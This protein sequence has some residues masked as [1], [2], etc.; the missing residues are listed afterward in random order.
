MI[1]DR[2]KVKKQ[3]EVVVLAIDGK[4]V[5]HRNK[6]DLDPSHVVRTESRARVDRSN[7]NHLGNLNDK[8]KSLHI[9]HDTIYFFNLSAE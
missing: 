2:I 5:E 9:H 3:E 4:S 8:S 1:D 6:S 7:V